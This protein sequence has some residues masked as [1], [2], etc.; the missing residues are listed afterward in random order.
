MKVSIL[1]KTVSLTSLLSFIL[2]TYTGVVMYFAP[3]GRVA[4]WVDWHIFG[5]NR[6]EFTGV[7]TTIS[8]LFLIC[9]IL[10]I[11]LNWKPIVNYLKNRNRK[12]VIFNKEFIASLALSVAVLA[13]TLNYKVPFSTILEYFEDVKYEIE[14]RAGNPPF[15]HAELASFKGLAER[16]GLDVQRAAELVRKEGYKLDDLTLTLKD[17]SRANDTTPA[18]LY[19]IMEQADKASEVKESAPRTGLGRRSLAEV[20]DTL[21]LSADDAVAALE[22]EGIKADKEMRFKDIANEAGVMPVEL[23]EIL[24]QSAK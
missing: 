13:G 20:A 7:H 19:K 15:P 24:E 12:I 22:A 10:H 2:L 23:F 18:N 16:M 8:L 14:D 6:E 11:Y 5:M 17:I 1:R 3:H 4:Y 21:G 9:M